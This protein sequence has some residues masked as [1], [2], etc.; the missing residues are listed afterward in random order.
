MTIPDEAVDEVAEKRESLEHFFN[1]KRSPKMKMA[2]L[3][4]LS[5]ILQSALSKDTVHAALRHIRTAKSVSRGTS[6]NWQ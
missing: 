2:E 4:E 6:R 3:A 5:D 1:E